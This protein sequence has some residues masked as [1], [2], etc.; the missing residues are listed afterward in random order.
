MNDSSVL[1]CPSCGRFSGLDANDVDTASYVGKT[2]CSLCAKID[3]TVEGVV[4]VSQPSPGEMVNGMKDDVLTA[5]LDCYSMKPKQRIRES[6][7]KEEIQ[8]AW[9]MWDGDKQRN[10]AMFCFYGWIYKY[11]PY[12]LTFRFKGDRWQIVHSWLIQITR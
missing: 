1:R 10:E 7:A 6:H 11:R 9:L 2:W 3:K 8:R 5:W 12:F 4:F